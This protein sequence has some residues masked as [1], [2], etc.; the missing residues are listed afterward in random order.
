MSKLVI[1]FRVPRNLHC[2]YLFRWRFV[3]FALDHLRKRALSEN[4]HHLVPVCDLAAD[5]YFVVSFNVVEDWIALKLAVATVVLRLFFLLV[6][7]PDPIVLTI[8]QTLKIC[9]TSIRYRTCIVN[10]TELILSSSKLLNLFLKHTVLVKFKESLVIECLLQ[11]T[12]VR[13]FFRNSL[14]F[15]FLLMIKTFLTRGS[16]SGCLVFLLFEDIWRKSL[17]S[18][19]ILIFNI[20]RLSFIVLRQ[21]YLSD[22]LLLIFCIG[23]FNF[24]IVIQE[25]IVN[26]DFRVIIT[27]RLTVLKLIII[28]I[29]RLTD[30]TI[31]RLQLGLRLILGSKFDFLILQ[32]ICL[33]FV[34][35]LLFCIFIIQAFIWQGNSHILCIL[36]RRLIRVRIILTINML[37]LR[38]DQLLRF[39][40]SWLADD[41]WLAAFH[42]RHFLWCFDM[43]NGHWD[44][45][46]VFRWLLN[47]M[48]ARGW[49]LLI[50]TYQF[51]GWKLGRT[52]VKST[53]LESYDLRLFHVLSELLRILIS[54]DWTG[55][56][57]TTIWFL[58]WLSLEVGNILIVKLNWWNVDL[59]IGVSFS[60]WMNCLFTS[61]VACYR[62]TQ[63]DC[64]LGG[65]I[66]SCGC[67]FN[68]FSCTR[69]RFSFTL[70]QERLRLLGVNSVGERFIRLLPPIS[71]HAIWSIC[72]E[73]R[74]LGAL[75]AGFVYQHYILF[76]IAR[77]L[78]SL[79]SFS[80]SLILL[81]N[82]LLV[83]LINLLF[84][85][86]RECVS[87]YARVMVMFL[88]ERSALDT[89]VLV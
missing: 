32:I 10:G 30:V 47:Y 89:L 26:F 59:V 51:N 75:L 57:I 12:I 22:K 80:S 84:E 60:W 5:F 17:N 55:Q 37:S 21:K 8:F 23:D 6:E 40:F 11:F 69:G 16:W 3:I 36:L 48:F 13:Q 67:L 14:T 1:H 34:T 85:G 63:P 81:Q 76:I 43:W 70:L 41:A 82:S 74:L 7:C 58:N 38:L 39:L 28:V 24:L 68:L 9:T 65:R 61:H 18:F 31:P 56:R 86:A 42:V 33:I 52:C 72:C 71:L 83:L 45:F 27:L 15:A 54:Q 29:D 66:A 19:V 73:R 44:V 46:D 77:L 62:T 2:K 25:E 49:L 64:L 53:L 50:I 79:R 78:I 35:L 20:L 88:L 87:C 4:F